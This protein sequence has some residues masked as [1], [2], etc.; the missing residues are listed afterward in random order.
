M[1]LE[2]LSRCIFV[3]FKATIICQN[4]HFRKDNSNVS[5]SFYELL[6]PSNSQTQDDIECENRHT[7]CYSN[8]LL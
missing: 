8:L 3:D 1:R 6:L 2:K 5:S 7:Q 4:T